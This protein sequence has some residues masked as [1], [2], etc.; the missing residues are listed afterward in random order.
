MVRRWAYLLGTTALAMSWTQAW[1]EDSLPA[2]SDVNG[3]FA[4]GGGQAL[5]EGTYF[6]DASISLPVMHEMGLQVDGLVGTLDGDGVAGAAAHLFWRDPSQGLVGLYA[7][8]L[9]STAGTN[10]TIANAGV[11]LTSSA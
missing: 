5:G 4:I 1:A 11:E 2:V 9:A 3:K 7:S 10:Y 6:V 8:S